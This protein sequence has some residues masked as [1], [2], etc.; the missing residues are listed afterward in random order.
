MSRENQVILRAEQALT[1]QSNNSA[2]E[3]EP[4]CIAALAKAQPTNPDAAYGKQIVMMR[5]QSQ[6]REVLACDI[7]GCDVKVVMDGMGIKSGSCKLAALCLKEAWDSLGAEEEGSQE[8]FVEVAGAIKQ[9]WSS[10][11][12]PNPLCDF[13]AGQSE[14]G[15][16][17]TAGSCL[18]AQPAQ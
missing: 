7:D 4:F 15:V 12:C 16:A 10:F 6:K 11:E 1:A 3:A 8:R 13:S 5:L 2:V 17:G 9:Q 18:H 14:D